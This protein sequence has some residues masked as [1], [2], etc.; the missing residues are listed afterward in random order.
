MN[1]QN[2]IQIL[3]HAHKLYHD[4]AFVSFN[5]VLQFPTYYAFIY[6]YNNT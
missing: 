4:L 3:K 5:Y 6:P 1:V 2:E